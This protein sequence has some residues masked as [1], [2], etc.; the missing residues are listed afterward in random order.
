MEVEAASLIVGWNH[1]DR[2]AVI[3]RVRQL[4]LEQQS[5]GRGWIFGAVAVGACSGLK[6]IW[7]VEVLETSL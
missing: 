1:R 2:G 7:A 3:E 5:S 4:D 6:V